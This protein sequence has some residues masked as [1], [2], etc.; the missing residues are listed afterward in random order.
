MFIYK[1]IALRVPHV[2][3]YHRII[4]LISGQRA[5]LIGNFIRKKIKQVSTFQTLQDAN[6]SSTFTVSHIN[7]PSAQ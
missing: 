6:P 1:Y 3:L 5:T 2:H 4:K 7:P